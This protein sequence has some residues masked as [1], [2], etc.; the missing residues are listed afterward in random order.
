M[1]GCR[2]APAHPVNLPVECAH[3]VAMRT[4]SAHSTDWVGHRLGYPVV[5][6]AAV[7]DTTLEYETFG[8]END[9]AV[10]LVMGLG[11]QMIA[12][13]ETFC[14]AI[15]DEGF[16][17]IRYDN[18]DVGLSTKFD[19]VPSGIS[20][21]PSAVKIWFSG[22]SPYQLSDMAADGF[23]LLDHLDIDAA[24]VVG[25]SMGG[26]IV[27]Q[28]A[29]DRPERLLSMTSIMSTTGSPWVG[30]ASS[31][32]RQMMFRS[33]AEH[34]DAIIDEQLSL[35][36][37]LSPHHFVEEESR[38]YA[39][40]SYQR[41]YYPEGIGRQLAAIFASGDRTKLLRR[42]TVPTLVI[43][44]QADTLVHISGGRATAKAIPDAVLKEYETMG[45]DL[46]PD[47]WPDMIADIVSHARQAS[48]PV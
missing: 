1:S 35:R 48:Q 38:K 27:Q 14:Q 5:M 22:K 4:V 6:Q 45:H 30:R 37:L 15:A 29:I 24:H 33:P 44:G 34:P 31:R 21:F 2:T 43:H 41:S 39:L 8:S 40:A 10:L 7:G 9:P 20:G 12:W 19:G 46:P 13:H 28:M 32:V 17:V 25:A 26:M 18:R 47:L 23:G 42:V 3:T 16:F 36:K 11:T